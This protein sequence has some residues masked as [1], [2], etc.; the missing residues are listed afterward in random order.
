MQPSCPF[1][2]VPISVF[3]LPYYH[4]PYYGTR[5]WYHTYV[6]VAFEG[7]RGDLGLSRLHASGGFRSEQRKC[8]T[9]R[10]SLD[11]YGV[12]APQFAQQS[13]GDSEEGIGDF[14]TILCRVLVLSMGYRRDPTTF[15]G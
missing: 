2:R 4:T 13:K 12:V 7:G 3:S 6:V 5:V 11:R 1:R 14:F 15:G 10:A 8:T 9:R